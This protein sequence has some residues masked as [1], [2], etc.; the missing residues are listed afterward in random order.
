MEGD[1]EGDTV[2]SPRGLGRYRWL[3]CPTLSV[4]A[5]FRLAIDPDAAIFSLVPLL[6]SPPSAETGAVHV[7]PPHPSSLHQAFR[8]GQLATQC[9]KWLRTCPSG[10]LKEA[11]EV[12]GSGRT[13]SSEEL[14][15]VEELVRELDAKRS[16]VNRLFGLLNFVNIVMFFSIIGILATVGPAVCAIFGPF[17]REYVLSL[18]QAV[19]LRLLR[20]LTP[21]FYFLTVTLPSLLHRYCLLE[22]SGYA[23]AF[24]LVAT[25]SAYPK[26]QANM[27]C[28]VA[29]AGGLVHVP[30]LMYSASLHGNRFT[31]HTED[32]LL[33]CLGELL[34]GWGA[35]GRG[36]NPALN[37]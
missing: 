10:T 16:I 4:I 28:M 32:R 33:M 17:F 8:L 6:W 18:I 25:A 19:S 15:G 27:G 12:V 35:I 23:L 2:P 7:V 20:L 13:V 22:A 36:V 26:E 1:Q 21:P 11:E 30:L 9:S 31:G 3:L 34:E 37:L 29:V 24:V 14:L 5:L